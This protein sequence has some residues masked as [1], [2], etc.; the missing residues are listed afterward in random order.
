M[1]G[2]GSKITWTI[3]FVGVLSPVDFVDAYRTLASKYSVGQDIIQGHVSNISDTLSV[4][5]LYLELWFMCEC[6]VMGHS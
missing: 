2:V 5:L 3:G 6:R 1:A 4:S